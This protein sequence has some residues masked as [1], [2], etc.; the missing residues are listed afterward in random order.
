VF[1]SEVRGPDSVSVIE[2]AL[3]VKQEQDVRMAG[4]SGESSG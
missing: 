1:I 4:E 3:V 2:I